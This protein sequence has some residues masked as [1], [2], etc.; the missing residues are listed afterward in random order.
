MI[1]NKN[2][3]SWNKLFGIGMPKTG[4]SSLANACSL[5][6]LS[7]LH[8]PDLGKIQEVDMANDLPVTAHYK[9]L[10]GLFPNSKFILTVRDQDSWEKSF[11]EHIKIQNHIKRGRE[12]S[13]YHPAFIH[14][15][16]LYGTHVL[17]LDVVIETR[18]KHEQ[19]V[20]EY[21]KKR[22]DDLLIMDIAGGD[23]WSMLCSFI[24]FQIPSHPFPHSNKTED[25]LKK[26]R[27]IRS[28]L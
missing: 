7:S 25:R 22:K 5:L 14:R 17:T 21:F 24:D 6:G 3:R 15:V 12:I 28:N 4:T 23:S 20:L 26:L 27:K 9:K 18:R 11:S 8:F 19:D 1:K 16:K 13:K 10:D 2:P